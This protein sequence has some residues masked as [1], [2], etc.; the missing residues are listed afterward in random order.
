MTGSARV[1]PGS[2]CVSLSVECTGTSF[3]GAVLN[4]ILHRILQAQD[5]IA[6]YFVVQTIGTQARNYSGYARAPIGV[7]LRAVNL[8]EF[9][10]D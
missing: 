2:G 6:D 7:G 8:L 3:M 1:N 9:I 10:G 5:L 4:F